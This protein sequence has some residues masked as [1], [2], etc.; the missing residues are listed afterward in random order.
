MD[1]KKLGGELGIESETK[2][3]QHGAMIFVFVHAYTKETRRKG[4][5]FL[6]KLL[7]LWIP[8]RSTLTTSVYRQLEIL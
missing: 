6:W 5:M 1:V 8:C 3:T 7:L 4:T 2:G